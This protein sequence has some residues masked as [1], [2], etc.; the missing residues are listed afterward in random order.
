M[1]QFLAH[2]QVEQEIRLRVQVPTIEEYWTF[3]MG[4]SAV[5]IAVAAVE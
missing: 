2:S 5:G 1:I 4:T 3:R